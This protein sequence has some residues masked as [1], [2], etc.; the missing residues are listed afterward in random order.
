MQVSSG[1]IARRSGEY[2]Q[3]RG[4]PDSKLLRTHETYAFIRKKFIAAVCPNL[5]SW[6]IEQTEALQRPVTLAVFDEAGP[7]RMEGLQS[8]YH[9]SSDWTIRLEVG[10]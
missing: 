8:S 2:L 9:K 7:P 3:S 10:Q 6:A 4:L 1:Q 5:T